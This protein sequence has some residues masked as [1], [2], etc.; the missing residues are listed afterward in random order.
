M[1]IVWFQAVLI[2]VVVAHP[3]RDN[4]IEWFHRWSYLAGSVLVGWV[5]ATN[6][7]TRQALRLFLAAPG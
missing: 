2:L 3:F 5:I 4:I 7:R 6:G 1:G